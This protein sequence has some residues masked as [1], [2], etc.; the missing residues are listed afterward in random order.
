MGVAGREG[1]GVG[2]R[3][4]MRMRI[5]LR[6]RTRVSEIG[7]EGENANGAHGVSI[8]GWPL[9]ADCLSTGLSDQ[10]RN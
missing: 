9:D 2:V 5:G 1:V 4:R 6:I 8:C 10:E 3:V 7:S